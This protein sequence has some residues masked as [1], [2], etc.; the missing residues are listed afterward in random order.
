M[1]FL[2]KP[3]SFFAAAVIPLVCMLGL[4]ETTQAATA[5]GITGTWGTQLSTQFNVSGYGQRKLKGSGNCAVTLWDSLNA[6]F[7]CTGF[8]DGLSQSYSGGISVVI[9]RNKLNWSLNQA[10]LEQV[11]SNMKSLLISKSLKNGYV[12]DPADISFQFDK[13]KYRPIKLSTNLSEPETAKG[14]IKGRAVQLI[15]GKYIV[16]PFTY[17]LTIKFL[18][19]VP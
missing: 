6:G 11:T 12:L 19:R 2:N 16:K 9:R 7:A 8:A 18:A 15:K 4:P 3:T 14:T 10:G 5:T 13:F 17:N 1:N